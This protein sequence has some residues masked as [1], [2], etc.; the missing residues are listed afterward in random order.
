MATKTTE[1]LHVITCKCGHEYMGALDPLYICP[2]C[3]RQGATTD[4][5]PDCTM[6]PDCACD[7]CFTE[8]EQEAYW[9][10]DRGA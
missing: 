6:S 2:M 7:D 5:G 10:P 8:H 4:S 3:H 1:A 9:S